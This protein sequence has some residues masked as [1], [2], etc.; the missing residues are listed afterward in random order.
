MD[1]NILS[2][3]KFNFKE[4]NK[5]ET[6]YN[7]GDICSS[8]DIVLSGC[9]VAYSLSQNGSESVV[10]EFRKNSVIGANLLFGNANA[11]RATAFTFFFTNSPKQDKIR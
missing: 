1:E 9:L 2:E 11:Y 5:N 10:F 3:V 8:M 6:I 7:Q 4:Y